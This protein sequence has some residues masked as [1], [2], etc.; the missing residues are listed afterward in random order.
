M[1]KAV[2]L[3][4]TKGIMQLRTLTAR[5]PSIGTG[6]AIGQSKIV[7]KRERR[8]K[9]WPAPLNERT[10]RS[11]PVIGIVSLRGIGLRAR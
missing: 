2:L 1:Y 11:D 6:V 9:D 3:K 5:L 4:K 7:I 8:Q 10:A